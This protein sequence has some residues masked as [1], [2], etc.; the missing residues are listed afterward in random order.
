MIVPYS[1]ILSKFDY[2]AYITHEFL[3]LL[4]NI[5]E[6]QKGGHI[7]D[8][9]KEVSCNIPNLDEH[10]SAFFDKALDVIARAQES[11]S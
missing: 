2:P 1:G 8:V 11:S 9:V 7:T 3:S 10:K 4:G 5:L 6:G